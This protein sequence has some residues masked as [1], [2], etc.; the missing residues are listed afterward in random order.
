MEWQVE[1]ELGAVRYLRLPD[2]PLPWAHGIPPSSSL[3]VFPRATVTNT[4]AQTLEAMGQREATALIVPADAEPPTVPEGVAVL[5][6]PDRLADI[7]KAI[8]ATL[9]TSRI[10]RG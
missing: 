3:L 1:S 9:L 8:E 5:R 7:D 2:V 4:L 6:C 10:S